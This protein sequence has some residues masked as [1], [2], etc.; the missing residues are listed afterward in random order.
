MNV[1]EGYGH[2][3]TGVQ[4]RDALRAGYFESL[5]ASREER[6]WDPRRELCGF[7]ESDGL[8]ERR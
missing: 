4:E 1:A 7:A 3:A 8:R 5:T 2:D 6:S